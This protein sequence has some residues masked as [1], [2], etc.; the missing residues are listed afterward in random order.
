MKF[1]A[2][3]HAK[4][5]SAGVDIVTVT[6]IPHKIQQWVHKACYNANIDSYAHSTY[7][8]HKTFGHATVKNMLLRNRQTTFRQIPA[9]LA[10][11]QAL[12]Y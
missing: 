12:Y 3:K 2:A 1:P 9:E 6:D 11:W 4:K 7:Q 8:P 5:A 10:L